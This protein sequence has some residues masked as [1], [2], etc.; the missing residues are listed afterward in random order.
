MRWPWV[1]RE[2]VDELRKQLAASEAERKHLLELLLEKPKVVEPPKPV[3]VSAP[4]KT[5]EEAP[6]NFTTPFDRVL[7]RFDHAN[8]GGGKLPNQKFKARVM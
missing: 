5:S 4:E 7:T 1:S 3:L 6:I 2:L 8:I